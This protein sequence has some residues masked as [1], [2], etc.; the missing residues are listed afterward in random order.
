MEALNWILALLTLLFWGGA[1]LW[2]FRKIII[3][4]WSERND[5]WFRD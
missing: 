4:A 1:G 3:Q 5:K 2:Y